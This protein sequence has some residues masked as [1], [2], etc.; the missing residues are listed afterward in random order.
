MNRPIYF[1]DG[2]QTFIW[3]VLSKATGIGVVEQHKAEE[4]IRKCLEE[5]PDPETPADYYIKKFRYNIRRDINP[6]TWRTLILESSSRKE[7]LR[8][9]KKTLL[10]KLIQAMLTK[11]DK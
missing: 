4:W 6:P 1:Q 7:D 9:L 8:H 3:L 2:R 11:S 10:P 5:Y